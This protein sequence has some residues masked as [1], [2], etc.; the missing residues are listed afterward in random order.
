MSSDKLVELVEDTLEGAVGDDE[1]LELE[2][3]SSSSSVAVIYFLGKLNRLKTEM[4]KT[5][6]TNKKLDLLGGMLAVN[7]SI[8]V[9]NGPSSKSKGL[10]GRLKKM[11]SAFI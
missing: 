8:S 1:F 3:G 4:L 7:A 2:E 10:L 9:L 11:I 6:D 5:E